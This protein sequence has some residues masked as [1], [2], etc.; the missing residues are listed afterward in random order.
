MLPAA[1]GG[2]LELGRALGRYAALPYASL[3]L[4]HGDFRKGFAE[5]GLNIYP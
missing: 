3:A 4:E 2:R 5:F 1:G